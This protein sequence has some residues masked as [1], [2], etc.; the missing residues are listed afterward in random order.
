VP[1]LLGVL[2]RWALGTAVWWKGVICLAGRGS[3]GSVAA[4]KRKIF[5]EVG[6][7]GVAWKVC[8]VAAAVAGTGTAAAA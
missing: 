4:G 2:G 7:G 6:R 1:A 3:L 8:A 5:V